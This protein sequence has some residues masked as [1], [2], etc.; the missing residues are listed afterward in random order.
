V[1]DVTAGLPEPLPGSP[2]PLVQRWIDEADA[3]VPN[4]T[5]MTLAT[6]A[7]DGSPSARMVICRGFD[8]E[9]GWFVFYSDQTSPKGRELARMPRAALVFYWQPLARQIRVEGPVTLAPDADADRYWA[10]RPLDARLAAVV[11]EQSEPIASRAAL[12]EKFEAARRQLGPESRRPHHWVG[13]R[14]WAERVELWV[15]GPAR[16]H[17]RGSWRRSLTPAGDGFTGGNWRSTR[18][19]P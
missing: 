13:Y 12:V 1:F 10:S 19:Q 17:D 5:A 16:L 7:P 4:A 11:S 6:T 18:L 9:A 3:A 2:L 15:S 14:V 8:T